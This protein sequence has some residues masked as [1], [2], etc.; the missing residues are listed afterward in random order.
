[1]N[2]TVAVV[3]R[4]RE[5]FLPALYESYARQIYPDTELRILDDS[6]RPSPFFAALQDPRVHYRHLAERASI[7]AKRNLLVQQAQGEWIGHFDDDDYYAE[8]YIAS[9]LAA[10]DGVD[11]VKLAAWFSFSRL[12]R[13]LTWWD[14][15]SPDALSYWQ[16]GDGLQAAKA[17]HLDQST[18]QRRSILGYGFSYF[19]RRNV[20]LAHPF[21][22]VNF[23][24][25]YPMVEAF[26]RAG[27]LIRL[28]NDEQGL[29]LHQLHGDNSSTVSPQYRL[30]GFLLHRL[31]PGFDRYDR[32]LQGNERQ[33]PERR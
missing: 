8:P 3:T 13:S 23:G 19:Y 9:M 5:H 20:G 29:V 26:V 33:P 16:T 11:F 6:D 27:G 7:G 4:N 12:S 1:M 22:E 10:A 17:E 2:V 30:P 21:P 18:L 25:D 15:R 28:K 24:E 31:F 14:T 32:L